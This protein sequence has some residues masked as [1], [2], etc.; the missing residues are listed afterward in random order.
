MVSPREIG[1]INKQPKS[2]LP[3]GHCQG[4]AR[5]QKISETKLGR[6]SATQYN[7]IDLQ[8]AMAK[9]NNM[10]QNPPESMADKVEITSNNPQEYPVIPQPPE[11]TYQSKEEFF[12]SIQKWALK[13]GFAISTAASYEVKHR[14]CVKYQCDKSGT[15][16]LHQKPIEPLEG[17]KEPNITP[18]EDSEDPKLPN[19]SKQ[20]DDPTDTPEDTTKKVQMNNANQSWKAK[21]PFRLLFKCHPTIQLHT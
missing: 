16:R 7:M 18:P 9:T 6:T 11:A 21:C 4:Y 12:Q 3:R 13:H 8:E 20:F 19:E 2:T 10:S 17:S 15:Y 5:S 1:T 14:I